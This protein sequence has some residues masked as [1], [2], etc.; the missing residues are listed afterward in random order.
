MLENVDVTE[1]NLQIPNSLHTRAAQNTS[2]I[3]I[4]GAWKEMGKEVASGGMKGRN[5]A[6]HV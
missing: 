4:V 2:I 5:A 3:S 1:N 6:C